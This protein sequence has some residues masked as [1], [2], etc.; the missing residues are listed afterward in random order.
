MAEKYF[1][2][3]SVCR[4]WQLERKAGL[5]RVSWYCLL[6]GWLLRIERLENDRGKESRQRERLRVQETG[7][8]AGGTEKDTHLGE[9]TS[10]ATAET[11][12]LEWHPPTVCKLVNSC[13][14]NTYIVGKIKGFN[15]LKY[16]TLDQ[17]LL[18]ILL[19]HGLNT[20]FS[21]IHGL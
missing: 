14:S 9:V 11:E 10:R 13:F 19:Q 7:R 6:A 2:L 16:I 15:A 4:R 12:S 8:M 1:P 17:Y 5:N 18:K 20:I 21:N 3:K